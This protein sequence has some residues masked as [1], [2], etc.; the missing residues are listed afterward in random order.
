MDRR[1]VE[2][3]CDIVPTGLKP[4]W[5]SPA[6]LQHARIVWGIRT[7]GWKPQAATQRAFST[8]GLRIRGG[9][10]LRIRAPSALGVME[11]SPRFR[12]RHSHELPLQGV[13]R[14]LSIQIGTS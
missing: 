10:R 4:L 9:L 8:R 1:K 6:C 14:W 3:I 5:Q 7:W 13:M 12:W 2:S 11:R